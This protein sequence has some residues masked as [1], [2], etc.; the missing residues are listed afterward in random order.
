MLKHVTGGDVPA[1]RSVA[2]GQRPDGE[3]VGEARMA[4]YSILHLMPLLS[5]ENNS[6]QSRSMTTPCT[7]RY[8]EVHAMAGGGRSHQSE[9]AS[10]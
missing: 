1:Q 6:P 4:R 7:L 9:Q 5:F 10:C 8:H 3:V 2:Y